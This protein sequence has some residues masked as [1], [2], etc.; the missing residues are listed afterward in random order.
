MNG[1]SVKVSEV[2]KRKASP[3]A[4]QHIIRD[5]YVNETLAHDESQ[6]ESC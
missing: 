3:K 6:N 4:E 1:E 2:M 5:E